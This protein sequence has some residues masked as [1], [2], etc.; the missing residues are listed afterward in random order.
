MSVT[1]ATLRH[2]RRLRLDLEQ[3]TDGQLRELTRAYVDA[4]DTVVNQLTDALGELAEQGD[5]NQSNLLR[6][7]KIASALQAIADSLDQLAA[8]TSVVITDGAGQVTSIAVTA[9]AAIAGSPAT[10]PVRRPAAHHRERGRH[11]HDRGPHRTPDHR[12]HP[13]TRPGRSGRRPP[14]P[15]ARRRLHRQPGQGGP[16]HGPPRPRRRRRPAAVAG[17]GHQPHRTERRRPRRHP[18]MG[19]RQ[20]QHPAGL[21]MAF[22]TG[23]KH[24]PGVLGAGRHPARTDRDR[25]RRARQLPLHPHG[26]HQDVAGTRP[27]PGRA[28]PGWPASPP[29][30]TS[31]A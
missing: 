28:P 2:M 24:L 10:Q 14:G 12:P 19:H 6:S 3:V 15:R 4:W 9:Q 21:G 30:T 20:Q 27:R 25:P 13:P 11:R 1:A 18:G 8:T 31:A 29:K 16:R 7:S 5:L 22:V 23:R 26:P 17:G